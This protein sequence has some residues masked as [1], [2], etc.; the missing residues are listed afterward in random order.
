MGRA[1]GAG[2]NRNKVAGFK[3]QEPSSTSVNVTHASTTHSKPRF[4]T[5]GACWLRLPPDECTTTTAA[6]GS[7]PEPRVY[8]PTARRLRLPAKGGS[9]TAACA[10]ITGANVT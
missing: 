7:K 3:A 10:S 5:A 1:R 2:A 6:S 8:A 4:Y 9:T